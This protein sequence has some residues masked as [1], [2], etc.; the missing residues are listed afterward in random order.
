MSNPKVAALLRRLDN[1]A[2]EQLCAEVVRLAEE[3]ER[4]RHE[5]LQME[6]CADGWREDAMNL[7]EQLAIV[8]GGTAGIMQSGELVVV[9]QHDADLQDADAPLSPEDAAWINAW[10]AH[11]SADPAGLSREIA[12]HG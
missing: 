2:Q 3:T 12:A 1:Q 5:L 7:H 11:D 4:L 6:S 10:L 9:A 8:T